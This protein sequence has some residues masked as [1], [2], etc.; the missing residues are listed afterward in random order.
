MFYKS[1]FS[2]KYHNECFPFFP[3]EP[4]KRQ[5]QIIEALSPRPFKIPKRTTRV[6]DE[7]PTTI[8]FG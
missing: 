8:P 4:P 1:Y 3:V 5:I 2:T 6:D 7:K